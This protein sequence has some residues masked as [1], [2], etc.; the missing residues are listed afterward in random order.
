[1]NKSKF[2]FAVSILAL[3]SACTTVGT[4]QQTPAQIAQQV[5]GPTQSV[6]AVLQA[7]KGIAASGQ[8]VLNKAAPQITALCSTAST[9]TKT[10]LVSL[11][12][13]AFN[14]VLPVAEATHPE[15]VPDLVAVQAIAG[16]VE[17][18]VKPAQ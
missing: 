15:L 9:A 8:A 10:D 6:I 18:Q 17:T 13:F 14:V 2:L 4:T 5:C 16:I 11:T 12:N 3:L 1:M 7:D